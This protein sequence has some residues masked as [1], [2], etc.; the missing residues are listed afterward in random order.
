V[1]YKIVG[2]SAKQSSGRQNTQTTID[3]V[4]SMPE[5][6]R[7]QLLL[8]TLLDAGRELQDKEGLD[9]ALWSWGAMHTMTFRHSLDRLPGAKAL[10]DLGPVARPGDGNTVD[11][12]GTGNAGFQQ[13]AGASYREIFDLSNWDNA[14]AINTPGQSG[15][16]GSRHY[17]DLLPLWEAGQYFPLAYSNDAVDQNATDV[18]TLVPGQKHLR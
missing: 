5:A 8:S 1:L 14:L 7:R 6:D 17:A 18:L 9:P 15:Q 12:T 4:K 13:I 16:P 11:A 2:D 3:Y 10:F